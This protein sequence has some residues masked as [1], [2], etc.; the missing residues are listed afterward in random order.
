[1]RRKLKILLLATLLFEMSLQNTTYLN[2][3]YQLNAG[4]I[5]WS[6]QKIISTSIKIIFSSTKDAIIEHNKN[7]IVNYLQ[8]NPQHID[9]TMNFIKKQIAENP[10]FKNKGEQL[11]N[12]LQEKLT[13]SIKNN[14]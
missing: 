7:K 5:K 9:Y 4:I 10:K 6:V 3:S 1:M 11:V 13:L 8:K 2:N 12:F 14:G